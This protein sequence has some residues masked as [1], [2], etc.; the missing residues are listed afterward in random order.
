MGVTSLH[1]LLSSVK[2]QLSTM[3]V[4][5]HLELLKAF[6]FQL[7]FMWIIVFRSHML[8]ATKLVACR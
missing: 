4:L 3:F 1:N 7:T 5:I 6:S 8:H 2:C